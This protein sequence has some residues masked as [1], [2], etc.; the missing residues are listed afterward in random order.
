MNAGTTYYS[1]CSS[2]KAITNPIIDNG[3]NM[4]FGGYLDKLDIPRQS[5][6]DGFSLGKTR[7]NQGRI[8][9]KDASRLFDINYGYVGIIL[10]LPLPIVNGVYTG[11]S[12]LVNK[13]ILW[14]VNVGK[15]STCLPGLSAKL[16]TNGIEFSIFSSVCSFTLNDNQS[17][18]AANTPLWIEFIWD[19]SRIDF[20]S[21]PDFDATMAILVNGYQTA[22][23]NPPYMT[24]S[25]VGLNFCLL[26]TPFTT[27][28]LECIIKKIV[29]M[30]VF[31]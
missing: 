14:G 6:D 19:K 8:F 12:G 24:D 16:T 5:L 2:L 4:L 27:S 13:H 11:L 7:N 28:N 10:Q 26:D 3:V 23:G 30:G 31:L 1:D 17:N 20:L 15:F 22:V 9:C 29:C 18:I 25:L 21:T